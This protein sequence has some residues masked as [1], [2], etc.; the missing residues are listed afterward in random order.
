MCDG[1]T[2]SSWSRSVGESECVLLLSYGR[3]GKDKEKV[4]DNWVKRKGS[5]LEELKW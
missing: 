2:Q 5:G 4:P 1:A 3:V